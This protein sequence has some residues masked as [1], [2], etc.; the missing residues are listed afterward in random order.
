MGLRALARTIQLVQSPLLRHG[1]KGGVAL[2]PAARGY[3][4]SRI[5]AWPSTSTSRR[6]GGSLSQA[7][8]TYSRTHN[9]KISHINSNSNNMYNS[10]TRMCADRASDMM[11]TSKTA[12]NR[13][14]MM[15]KM[16]TMT[17][18][19]MH[20][21]LN[22]NKGKVVVTLKRGHAGKP[23]KQRKVLRSLGL[24]YVLFSCILIFQ[25]K[26]HW[27]LILIHLV[28]T[29]KKIDEINYIIWLCVSLIDTYLCMDGYDSLHVFFY[30]KACTSSGC[31]SEQAGN[32]W[33][34]S[35]SVTSAQDRDA[36]RI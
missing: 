17:N 20:E 13:M 29:S 27:S 10:R 22:N 31:S 35:E 36:R 8:D 34:D 6:C 25:F 2:A 9:Y 23:E 14:V 30:F 16:A 15:K 26:Y 12:E 32:T 11:I 5:H 4:V 1:D 7:M 33:H 21:L 24:K 19:R 28:T 3:V 18:V